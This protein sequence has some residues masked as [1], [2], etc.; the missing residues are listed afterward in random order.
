M[1]EVKFSTSKQNLFENVKVLL[2]I[3]IEAIEDSQVIEVVEMRVR[4][5]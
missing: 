1:D 3:E 4:G 2:N 5:N